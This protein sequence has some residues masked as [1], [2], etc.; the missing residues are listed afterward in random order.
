MR[1]TV[2]GFVAKRFERR[3]QELVH[4]PIKRARDFFLRGFIKIGKF[5]EQ[6]FQFLVFGFMPPFAQP[7]DNG[8][9]GAMVKVGHELFGLCFHDRQG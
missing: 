3:M 4:Q 8:C 7:L 5:V 6:T 1:R 9:R 2:A